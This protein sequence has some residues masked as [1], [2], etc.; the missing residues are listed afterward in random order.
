MSET[1]APVYPPIAREAHV[2]G[3]VLLLA[4]FDTAGRVT[5][6]HTVSG[7]P[8]LRV[9]AETFVKGWQADP[10]TGPRSCPVVV[11][12]ALPNPPVCGEQ[13]V[14]DGPQPKQGRTGTQH[15]TVVGSC[16]NVVAMSDPHLRVIRRKRFGIF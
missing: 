9:A 14:Q 11:E 12:F 3:T 8:M 15:Y 1:T 7:L 2:S 13:R 4:S 6:V 5:E 10:Y 16:V